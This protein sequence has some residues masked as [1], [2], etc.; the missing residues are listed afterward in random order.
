[1]ANSQPKPFKNEKTLLKLCTLLKLYT[2]L[3]YLQLSGKKEICSDLC[4][5]AFSH[6][7]LLAHYCFEDQIL[8]QIMWQG[9]LVLWDRP[10]IYI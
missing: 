7:L 8:T 3:W 4:P 5:V 9:G 2:L 6:L 10:G 1:M